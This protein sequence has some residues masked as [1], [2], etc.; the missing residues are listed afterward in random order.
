[1]IINAIQQIEKIKGMNKEQR[2]EQLKK[3]TTS[4]NIILINENDQ[5]NT[6]YEIINK[7]DNKW[8]TTY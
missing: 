6:A 4:K 2:N 1:M 7:E 8:Y 3:L 5:L